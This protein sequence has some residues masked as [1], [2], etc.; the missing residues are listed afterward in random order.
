MTVRPWGVAWNDSE[1]EVGRGGAG[2]WTTGEREVKSRTLFYTRK[3]SRAES[4]C[5]GSVTSCWVLV[6][7]LSHVVPVPDRRG[8]EVVVAGEAAK[9]ART[10]DS[11]M[12]P[13]R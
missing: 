7:L 5:E 9:A 4:C 12:L 6:L 13:S 2:L 3:P 11:P 10:Q 8:L 1:E